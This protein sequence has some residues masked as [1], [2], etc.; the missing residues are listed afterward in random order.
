MIEAI[1]LHAD[2]IKLNIFFD[3]VN[4]M[5]TAHLHIHYVTLMQS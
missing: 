3:K 1:N 4:F 2:K 5:S